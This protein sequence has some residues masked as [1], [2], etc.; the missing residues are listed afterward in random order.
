MSLP[1]LQLERID[2]VLK[3]YSQQHPFFMWA[4]Y[5]MLWHLVRL[6]YLGAS[7]QLQALW[8]D[9]NF[10]QVQGIH[11]VSISYLGYDSSPL[12]D[13]GHGTNLHGIQITG[14]P[15]NSKEQCPTL[16]HKMLSFNN[17]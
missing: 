12:S 10:G 11:P 17:K 4:W 14:K 5:S 16:I 9:G 15:T 3:V 13:Q 2:A 8:E 6:S 1:L 7:D